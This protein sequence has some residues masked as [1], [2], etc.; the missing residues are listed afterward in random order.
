ME[1]AKKRSLQE[2]VK[3]VL[4]VALL[5]GVPAILGQ[6]AVDKPEWGAWIGVALTVLDKLKFEWDKRVSEKE[7]GGI[8]PF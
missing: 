4:R 3:F 5:V 7:V 8:V 6:L 1:N 2:T